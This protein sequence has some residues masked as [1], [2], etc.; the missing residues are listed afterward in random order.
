MFQIQRKNFLRFGGLS[1]KLGHRSGCVFRN[2]A[3][4]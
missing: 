3:G 2:A 1:V 4:R